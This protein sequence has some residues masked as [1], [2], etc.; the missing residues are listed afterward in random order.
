M[1]VWAHLVDR[2]DESYLEF[3]TGPFEHFVRFLPE[4]PTQ[5]ERALVHTP[6]LDLDHERRFVATQIEMDMSHFEADHCQRL[7][8]HLH[9]M[10]S[11]F[12]NQFYISRLKQRVFDQNWLSDFAMSGAQFRESSDPETYPGS[13]T[14][15]ETTAADVEEPSNGSNDLDQSSDGKNSCSPSSVYYSNIE[16]EEFAQCARMM[17]R[18]EA[19]PRHYKAKRFRKGT[20]RKDKGDATCPD[21]QE[22][23]KP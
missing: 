15:S 14:I 17:R 7:Q 6:M 22:Q 3:L 10:D 1:S 9:M 8:T 5:A 11:Y 2:K 12:S 18:L 23:R 4:G 20:K 16:L 13:I 21:T 19:G